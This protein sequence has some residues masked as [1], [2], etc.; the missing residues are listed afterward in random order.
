MCSTA[1]VGWNVWNVLI[2]RVAVDENIW[3]W[4]LR[5]SVSSVRPAYVRSK[6]MG[7]AGARTALGLGMF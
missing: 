3:I 6:R 1:V 2:L 7:R 5:V 4:I